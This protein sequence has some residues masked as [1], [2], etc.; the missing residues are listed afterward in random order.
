M[1]SKAKYNNGHTLSHLPSA[2][3]FY[4]K[5]SK[6]RDVHCPVLHFVGDSSTLYY[7]SSK[8]QCSK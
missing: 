3:V 7:Q 8:I 5:L 1:Q 2:P 6:L 4:Y